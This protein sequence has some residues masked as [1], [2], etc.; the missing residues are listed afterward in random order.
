MEIN[1]MQTIIDILINYGILGIA[2][3]GFSEAVFLP[4]PMEFVFIPTALLNTS[5]AFIYSLVL[6]LFSTLGSIVGYYLGK[7]V[8]TPLLNKMISAD[9]FTKIKD[10]YSKNAFLTLL[11]SC[12][13]PIPYEVYVVSAGTFNINKTTFITASVISRIIRYLPQG[14]LITLFGR[15][16][17]QYIKNYTITVGIAVFAVF[18]ILRYLYGKRKSIDT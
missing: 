7:S 2:A 4:M 11:T 15:S 8:G 14:I 16:I 5:K 6:I 10:M 18:L 9:K 12:F 3:A 1:K 13:T 17:L